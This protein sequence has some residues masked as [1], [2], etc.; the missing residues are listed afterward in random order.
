MAIGGVNQTPP[1]TIPEKCTHNEDCPKDAKNMP[2]HRHRKGDGELAQKRGDTHLGTLEDDL[3]NF[4]R[5]PDDT[6]LSE[7][8]ERSGKVGVN[9]V[10]KE[11]RKQESIC[12]VDE[13]A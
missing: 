13:V 2:G 5:L 6:H 3:G 8:R 10:A 11:I 4:S 12:K 7:L 1:Y 9:A